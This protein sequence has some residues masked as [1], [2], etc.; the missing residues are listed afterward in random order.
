MAKSVYTT[1]FQPDRLRQLIQEQKTAKEIMKALSISRFTLKEHLL[2][3]QRQDKINYYIP[4]LIE[5]QLE[6][7]RTIRRR[8][9]YICSPG[10]YYLPTFSSSDTFEM[11]ERGDRVILKKIS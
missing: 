7:R 2:L 1:R 9:G 10:S 11:I 4:G 5:D 6:A 8:S 3:L